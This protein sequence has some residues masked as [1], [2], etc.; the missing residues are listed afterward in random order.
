MSP[1]D[2]RPKQT[3]IVWCGTMEDSVSGGLGG[4]NKGGRSSGP[5]G[6][7]DREEAG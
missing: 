1:Q 3:G 7:V 4:P 2:S 6:G 5:R